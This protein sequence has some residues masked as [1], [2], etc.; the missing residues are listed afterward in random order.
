MKLTYIYHTG[1]AIVTVS[2]VLIFDCWMDPAGVIPRILSTTNKPIYVFASHFHEDHFTKDILKWRNDNPTLSI[3]YVLSKDIMKRR[4]A[5]KEDAD[6]WMAKGSVWSN[7]I[8]NIYATGSNDSGV[9]WIVEV[10]DPKNQATIK[11]FFHAGDL[12]NWYARFLTL[13]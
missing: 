4:R 9:S 5:D 12:N 6:V 10:K 7:D 8:I 11:R 2:C 13:S 3:T 1:F